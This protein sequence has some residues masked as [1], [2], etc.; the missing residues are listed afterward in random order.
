MIRVMFRDSFMVRFRVISVNPRCSVRVWI[1]V[2]ISF[3]VRF[4]IS[5]MPMFSVSVRVRVMIRG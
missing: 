5:F 4:I 3:N 2:C 1:R